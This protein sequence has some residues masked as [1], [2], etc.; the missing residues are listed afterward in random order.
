M[1]FGSSLVDNFILSFSLKA[2]L[3]DLEDLTDLKVTI[4]LTGIVGIEYLVRYTSFSKGQAPEI[5]ITC[6]NLNFD[7]S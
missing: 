6:Q 5:T 2:F 7:I 1:T 4:L 3:Q